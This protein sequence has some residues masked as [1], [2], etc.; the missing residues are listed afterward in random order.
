MA[1]RRPTPH[2]GSLPRPGIVRVK[3]GA[4]HADARRASATPWRR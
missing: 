3:P 1:G 2:A 4:L